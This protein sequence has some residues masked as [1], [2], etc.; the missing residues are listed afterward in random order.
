MSNGIRYR[1][2]EHKSIMM[3]A[4]QRKLYNRV[5]LLDTIT[6]FL[7]VVIPLALSFSVLLKPNWVV[8]KTLSY[9]L[10]MLMLVLSVLF[11]KG[12]R[13]KKSLAASIQQEFD[14]YVY[15]MPWDN[16][17]F[18][19]QKN[20]SS[21]IVDYS[22]K[23]MKDENK[24]KQLV[25][26]YTP[27]VDE[28]TIFQGIFSCQRETYHW[29]VGLRKRYRILA[30][31]GITLLCI[32]IFGIGIIRNEFALNQL[33]RIIFILPMF[34]WLCPL[35]MELNIDIDRLE[36][37]EKNFLGATVK[38]MED[39]QFIQKSIF[40]HRKNAVKIPNV[41]YRYFKDNDEDKEHRLA[42]MY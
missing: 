1:Q 25:D 31:S 30:I 29:D 32:I 42:L 26:W 21:K 24:K 6:F 13:E 2:N 11:S 20:L 22:T 41:F 18:G 15:Q 27:V 5:N 37:L 7:S 35:C 33:S 16:K 14:I 40:D 8:L 19:K 38:D 39:L 3:L 12:I 34:K 17:I 36:E 23:I 4:A 28:M 9:L 10:S